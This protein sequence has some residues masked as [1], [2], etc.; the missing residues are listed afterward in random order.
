MIVHRVNQDFQNQAKVF[1]SKAK[2]DGILANGYTNVIEIA[3][4]RVPGHYV[5]DLVG[6]YYEPESKRMKNTVS[7]VFQYGWDTTP[8]QTQLSFEQEPHHEE[9]DQ[10]WYNREQDNGLDF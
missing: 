8:A 3:K 2:V 4:N 6:V 9:P 10:P 5:G 1:F 7:E